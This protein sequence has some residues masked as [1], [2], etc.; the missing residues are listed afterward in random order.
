M[1]V[2]PWACLSRGNGGGWYPWVVPR[3]SA[4]ISGQATAIAASRLQGPHDNPLERALLHVQPRRLSKERLTPED[5]RASLRQELQDRKGIDPKVS[6]L[7]SGVDSFASPRAGHQGF[8]G[9]LSISWRCVL[10]G[11]V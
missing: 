2:V 3:P 9:Q 7:K 10:G 5:I 4:Y 8:A 1:W 6:K 11:G